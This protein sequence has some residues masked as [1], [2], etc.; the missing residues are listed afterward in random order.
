MDFNPEYMAS[1]SV[2]RAVMDADVVISFP[3]FKTH[4]L[5]VI[6]GGIKNSYG[7]L[8]GAQ[9][10]K[11]HQAAGSPERF[12]EVVVDEKICI[13]CFCCQEI[14]PEKAIRLQ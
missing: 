11:L 7:I 2:S 5:T 1:V 12:H 9:K 4:G 10:A 6:T 13:T 8:P 3:K 14:C